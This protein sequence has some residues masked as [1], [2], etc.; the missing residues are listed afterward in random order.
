MVLITKSGPKTLK[1][2]ARTPDF[3]LPGTDGGTWSPESFRDARA[4]VVNFTCNHCPYAQAY[5][6]RYI[7][8]AREFIPQGAAFVAISA[9]DVA[10]YPADS[11]ENMKQ[12]AER[13]GYPFPYLFDGTQAT[14]RAFGAVCT[15]HVFVF[16]A[17]RRLAY[18]GR[19][20]DNWKDPA[21][22]TSRDLQNAIAAVLAG[23]PAPVA[24]TNPMGCSIKWK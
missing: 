1:I 12:L 18:E 4:L 19:I 9:N 2:G 13:K 23:R 16:D 15:P 5:D 20:D 6:D 21:A 11:F 10:T 22:V 17:A 14:A 8:L 24:T 7:A 3:A